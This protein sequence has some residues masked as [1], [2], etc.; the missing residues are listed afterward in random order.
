MAF[1]NVEDEVEVGASNVDVDWDLVLLVEEGEEEGAAGPD[2]S[3]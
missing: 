1:S 2:M 3:D